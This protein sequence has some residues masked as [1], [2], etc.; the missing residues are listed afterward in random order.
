MSNKLPIVLLVALIIGYVMLEVFGPKGDDWNPN[1]G[2]DKVQPFGSQLL[3]E[4]MEDIFPENKIIPVED[5]PSE[6][7]KEFQKERTNY[8][9]VQQVLNMDPVDARSLL[10]YVENGNNVFVSAVSLDG[11]LGDSLGVYSDDFWTRIWEG[12]ETASKD[13]YLKL[14]ERYDPKEVHY[15]LL[16]NVVYNHYYSGSEKEILGTNRDNDPVFIRIDRGEGS[17]FIHSIP[18]LFTNFFMVDEVNHEYISKVLSFLPERTTYWDEYYKPGKLHIDNQM[19][20]ILDQTSLRWSWMLLLVSLVLFI[21]FEGKRRQRIIPVIQAPAND[22][23]EFTRT[24]GR[25]YFLHGDHKDIAEKKIKFLF[26]YIR[27][28]WQMSTGEIDEDFRRRLAGKSGVKRPLVDNLLNAI[29]G[30]KGSEKVSEDRLL[31]LH[32][33]MEEFY[34]QCR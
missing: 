23:L 31:F 25:L 6:Q 19:S 8:V 7:L 11:A 17:F 20:Y 24:V 34:E 10:R 1:Y 4:G 15:P 22:T 30:V 16:D 9:I 18:Y 13:D 3:Y 12:N 5:A 21:L 2:R 27:N 28:R 26:E 33:Q 32:H 29:E 14:K